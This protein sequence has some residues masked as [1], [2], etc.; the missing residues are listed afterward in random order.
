[1]ALTP[2]SM[3]PLG[4]V[5]PDFN[6]LDTKTNKMVSLQQIK[7]NYATVVM[8]ICNHCPYVIHIRNKLVEITKKYQAKGIHFVAINSNDI[9]KYPAD[10]PENMRKEAE[11]HR[12]T[13]PYLFDDTQAIA[14]AYQA[15]CT[16]DFYI[17]D[18]KLACVYRGRFDDATPGNGIPV[19]GNDL[20]TALDTLLLGND[21][22]SDQQPSI[23]C[24]I[25]WK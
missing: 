4:T 22:N 13:F 5:A 2:S 23:G 8:F 19:T 3:L 11:L 14:K 10:N 9:T 20:S 7:S 24:N 17:F 25:K 16:P 12:Y 18:N 1:M 15:A 6:L 21:I